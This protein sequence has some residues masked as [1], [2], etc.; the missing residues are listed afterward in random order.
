MSIDL[1]AQNDYFL[2]WEE[3]MCGGIIFGNP[4]GPN[5]HGTYHYVGVY[6][7]NPEAFVEEFNRGRKKTDKYVFLSEY[8][9]GNFGASYT[10]YYLIQKNLVGTTKYR[11][12]GGQVFCDEGKSMVSC[13]GYC[14]GEIIKAVDNKE[15][16]FYSIPNNPNRLL[17]YKF[18]NNNWGG[19]DLCAIYDKSF[20]Q[21]SS[22]Y[23]ADEA[24]KTNFPNNCRYWMALKANGKT[25]CIVDVESGKE[26]YEYPN[27]IGFC[28]SGQF[29]K[30][31]NVFAGHFLKVGQNSTI[32]SLCS[33]DNIGYKRVRPVGVIDAYGR[34]IIPQLN[35]VSDFY[36]EEMTKTYNVVLLKDGSTHPIFMTGA[37]NATG[38]LIKPFTEN[39]QLYDLTLKGWK[40]HEPYGMSFGDLLRKIG[41]GGGNTSSSSDNESSSSSSSST[42]SKKCLFYV[43]TEKVH[44]G[45]IHF[46]YG[47]EFTIFDNDGDKVQVYFDYRKS[48]EHLS[49]NNDPWYADGYWVETKDLAV[50]KVMKSKGCPNFEIRKGKIDD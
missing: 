22:F 4:H 13:R 26:T 39:Q 2:K 23:L 11:I 8:K 28:E 3:S 41:L 38:K 37:Y 18:D 12:E 1:K 40:N 20:N 45:S 49:N 27:E 10:R 15:Y 29:G 42:S 6:S 46:D 31:K 17:G 25:N 19:D 33:L 48:G 44:K 5:N 16:K 50:K 43:N 30:D 24:I 21:L 47:Y 36:F 34:E 32:P 7:G 14:D 35:N 9:Y